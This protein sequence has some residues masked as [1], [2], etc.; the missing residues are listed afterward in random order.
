[1]RDNI[2]GTQPAFG[3]PDAVCP[4]AFSSNMPELQAFAKN[5][6]VIDGPNVRDMGVMFTTRMTVV[7]LSDGSVWMSSPVPV[8]FETLKRITALGPVT[9]LLRSV[10]ADGTLML[11]SVTAP[12][13]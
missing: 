10:R 4:M 1:M 11:I 5:I 12:C 3:Y 13:L 2:T 9:Y 7:K 8:S 6:W